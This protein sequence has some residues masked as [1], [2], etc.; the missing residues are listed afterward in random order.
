M[1]NRIGWIV[2]LF[3]M[4]V[5]SGLTSRLMYTRGYAKGF[6]VGVDDGATFVREEWC[7]RTDPWDDPNIPDEDEGVVR[8]IQ[9][10]VCV[11]SKFYVRKA[12]LPK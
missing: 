11:Y 4:A 5:C 2:L 12:D 9:G 8:P 7:K 6:E 3:V 1:K 10:G